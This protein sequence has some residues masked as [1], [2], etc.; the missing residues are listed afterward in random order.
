MVVPGGS[1]IG[2]PSPLRRV[3][4]H[5]APFDGSIATRFAGVNIFY[6]QSVITD[7]I[8]VLLS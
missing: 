7:R 3:V 6:R 1:F 2:R 5:A 4:V 8:Y